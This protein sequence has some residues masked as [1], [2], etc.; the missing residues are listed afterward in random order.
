V[1]VVVGSEFAAA[2]SEF[3]AAQ[4]LAQYKNELPEVSKAIDFLRN[5]KC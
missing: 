4:Q 3:A 2:G 1:F 5:L